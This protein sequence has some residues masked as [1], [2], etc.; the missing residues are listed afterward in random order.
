MAKIP[1]L[2]PFAFSP[3]AWLSPQ[4]HRGSVS[5]HIYWSKSVLVDN[6]SP[7]Q[8][9]FDFLIERREPNKPH[10]SH[11]ASKHN[12][13]VASS[14]HTPDA[15][16]PLLLNTITQVLC[17][18]GVHRLAALV[19]SLTVN[20]VLAV[21]KTVSLMISV[22]GAGIIP[23]VGGGKARTVNQKMMW[24]GVTVVLLGTVLLAQGERVRLKSVRARK[25]RRKSYL[26]S[27]HNTYQLMGSCTRTLTLAGA[28]F[29]Q[30]ITFV[31]TGIHRV[32]AS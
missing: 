26:Y 32:A 15:Y 11:S 9:S 29:K 22:L 4:G 16:A 10:L 8:L 24:S 6:A 3:D 2:P 18:S 7:S 17:A 31:I 19:S 27:P 13:P 23:G 5:C 30:F 14:V 28:N 12:S 21:R 20:L 25:S 1:I